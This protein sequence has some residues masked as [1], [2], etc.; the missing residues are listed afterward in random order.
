MK[1]VV[2]HKQYY[3][4][5]LFYPADQ[6]TKNF[7]SLFKTSNKPQ[8]SLSLAQIKKLKQLGFIVEVRRDVINLD[9]LK[10]KENTNE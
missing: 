6:W 9:E 1:L 8:K 5:H 7:I 3:G 2:E 10:S 4:H